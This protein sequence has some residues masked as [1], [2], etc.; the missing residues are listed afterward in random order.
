MRTL[1]PVLVI[2][3]ALGLPP[4]ATAAE[5]DTRLL[6]PGD[7]AGP[8]TGPA[9]LRGS[10]IARKAPPPP[11]ATGPERWRALAGERLWLVDVAGGEVVSCILDRTSTV[12]RRIVRCFPD[13]LPATVGR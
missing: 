8:D 12:G 3:T 6:A 4:A 13:D 9:I 1:L 10:A 2:A 7:I 5:P 11:P